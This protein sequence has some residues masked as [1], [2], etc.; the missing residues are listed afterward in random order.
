MSRDFMRTLSLLALLVAL[1]LAAQRIDDVP[2]AAAV[3]ELAPATLGELARVAVMTPGGEHDEK[4]RP[5]P[6]AKRTRANA[7][8]AELVPAPEADIRSEE[9]TSELQ[10]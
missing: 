7:I 10:S 4:M 6:A 1:P 8:A 3:A 2:H 9:H 5:A